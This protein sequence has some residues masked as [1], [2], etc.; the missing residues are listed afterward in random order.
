MFYKNKWL[1]KLNINNLILI[2]SCTITVLFLILGIH[3]F[4]S[5]YFLDP[6]PS[7]DINNHVFNLCI[8]NFDCIST[9]SDN[10]YYKFVNF[11]IKSPRVYTLPRDNYLKIDYNYIGDNTA[12]YQSFNMEILN[13]KSKIEKECLLKLEKEYKLKIAEYDTHLAK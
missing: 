13:L 7:L 8:N 4:F 9:S 10:L 6:N 2:Y 11:L 1:A 12:T 5:L 3:T